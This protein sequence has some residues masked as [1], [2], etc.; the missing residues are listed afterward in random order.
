M[1]SDTFRAWAAVLLVAIIAF[2]AI[3]ILG[4]V[5][6]S[7]RVDLTENRLYTLSEGT[8]S[9]VRSLPQPVTLKLYY[10][11]SAAMKGPES[12]RSYH[13]HFYYVQDLLR[14]YAKLSRG[15]IK[16]EIVD[17][18]PETDEGSDAIRYGLR[19]IPVTSEDA[20]FF[21]LVMLTPFG[22]E[23]TIPFLH[24]DRQEL[25]EYDLSEIIAGGANR[26][27]KR[28]GVLSSLDL[29]GN[30]F[31]P[32]MVQMLRMQGKIAPN[33]WNI[34]EQIRGDYELVSIRP[35]AAGIDPVD[36]LM[37]IHP[38]RLPE[39]TL[40][41]ID[42]YVMAGGKLAVFVDPHCFADHPPLDAAEA[43]WK[44]DYDR[45]SDLNRLLK[46]WGCEMTPGLFVADENLGVMIH[47]GDGGRGRKLLALME[48]KEP[49]LNRNE[50]ITARLKSVKTLFGGELKIREA[51]SFRATPLLSTTASGSTLRLEDVNLFRVDPDRI[52]EKYR[53]GA[54]PVT[55]GYKLTGRFESA[56]PGGP[57]DEVR[58][59]GGAPTPAQAAT[60]ESRPPARLSAETTILVFSD[61]DMISNLLAYEGGL[62]G[63]TRLGDN[64]GLVLG[65]IED[66]VGPDDLKSIR[67]RGK[68][69]RPFTVLDEMEAGFDRKIAGRIWTLQAEIDASQKELETLVKKTQEGGVGLMREASIAKKRELEERILKLKRDLWETNTE[70]RKKVE[71]LLTRLKVFNMVLGPLAVLALGVTVYMNGNL[72][73][74][75]S[76]RGSR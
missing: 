40:F 75:F 45:S 34:V 57:K 50:T 3:T 67:A 62:S 38:K 25:L 35:D 76:R 26:P 42:S 64:A 71:G 32:Y 17:P 4:I 61:V 23:K 47:P 14:E 72:K 55:L 21:G 59:S 37:V 9:I 15:R 33:A 12:M 22:Q 1:K 6:R 19:S 54:L 53:A 16:L 36:L 44:I 29:F 2:C 70:K 63:V 28:V 46:A 39:E 10:S 30:T 11:R 31:S 68:Y 41:A 73:R 20:F 43:Q 5:G 27:R 49:S 58:D 65:A 60:A 66:L 56:F 24:P 48:M 51:G 52:Q 8:K 13:N 69:F 74:L 7:W 18:R